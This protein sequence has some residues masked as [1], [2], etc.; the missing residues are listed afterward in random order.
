MISKN[1]GDYIV[2]FDAFNLPSGIYY[3]KI[4]YKDANIVKKMLL[5]K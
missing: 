3:Y 1:A 5:I 2:A 4:N